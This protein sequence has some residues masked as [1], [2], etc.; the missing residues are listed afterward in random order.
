MAHTER[1]HGTSREG[2]HR[3]ATSVEAAGFAAPAAPAHT[4]TSTSKPQQHTCPCKCRVA[5]GMSPMVP[6]SQMAHPERLMRVEHNWQDMI[7]MCV[8]AHRSNDRFGGRLAPFAQQ[9]SLNAL[10]EQ[11]SKES[12]TCR[13]DSLRER[14]GRVDARIQPPTY[15]STPCDPS[16]SRLRLCEAV[17]PRR[18]AMGKAT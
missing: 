6:P 18:R 4:R 2:S 9:K 3:A 11:L 17:A 5:M 10:F 8:E 16:P 1:H 12:T 14:N 15:L 13:S 7:N